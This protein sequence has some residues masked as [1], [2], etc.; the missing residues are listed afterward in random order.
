MALTNNNPLC[1]KASNIESHRQVC[2]RSMKTL[3]LLCFASTAIAQ[4]VHPLFSN[5]IVAHQLASRQSTCTADCAAISDAYTRCGNQSYQTWCGCDEIVNA[6]TCL[7]CLT[8]TTT[9]L[10]VGGFSINADV[11]RTAIALCKCRTDGNCT[12]Y[13]DGLY[14]CRATLSQSCICPVINQYVPCC[15]ECWKDNGGNATAIDGALTNCQTY[16]TPTPVCS[17]ATRMMC[18]SFAWILSSLITGAMLL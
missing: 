8:R 15:A 4:L 7:D 10:D 6:T 11:L 16:P 13:I 2:R 14:P 18:T 9:T 17:F 3:T 1:F 5:V 12:R